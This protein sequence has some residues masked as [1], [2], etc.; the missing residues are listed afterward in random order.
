MKREIYTY[1][2]RVLR[3]RC[4]NI[5]NI[6]QIK[7]LINDMHETMN[8]N[9]GLGLAAPQIGYPYNIV[10]TK[11]NKLTLIN[12]KIQ[13]KEGSQ[14]VEESCLSLPELSVSVKRAE[15]VMVH[16]KDL[17][18]KSHVIKVDSKFSA[19]LQHEIDHLKGITLVDYLDEISKKIYQE[20]I[21]KNKL[22]KFILYW[23]R[24][25]NEE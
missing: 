22:G 23:N 19:C 21:N 16:Y 9:G 24:R 18:M 15:K 13:K 14:V 10:T 4:E 17:K 7:S 11:F 25:E 1:P 2:H 6:K 8:K 3:Q 20:Q 12:P 5:T